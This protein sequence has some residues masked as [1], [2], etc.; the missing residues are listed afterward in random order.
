MSFDWLWKIFD[1]ATPKEWM[2]VRE[3][4]DD[5]WVDTPEQS[6]CELYTDR[7]AADAEFIAWCGTN[8]K[9]IRELIEAA[10]K[11]RRLAWRA[12]SGPIFEAYFGDLDKVLT[13][14]KASAP[15]EEK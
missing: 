13:A 12:Y 14:L 5:W 8:R 4:D 9:L 11:S 10:E 1:E 7:R 15:K 2:P 3:E 6:I